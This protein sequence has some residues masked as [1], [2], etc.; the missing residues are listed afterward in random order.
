MA[1]GIRKSWFDRLTKRKQKT[2]TQIEQEKD[3]L[4]SVN[5]LL[6]HPRRPFY[7]LYVTPQGKPIIFPE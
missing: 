6:E 4:K 1:D 7:V 2:K 5:I 3:V